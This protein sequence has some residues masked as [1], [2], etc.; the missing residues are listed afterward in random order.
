MNTNIQ[1]VRIIGDDNYIDSLIKKNLNKIPT[2]IFNYMKILAGLDTT[3]QDIQVPEHEDGLEIN[4]IKILKMNVN[5][6]I[7]QSDNV[8]IY[9]QT[10][11]LLT[12]DFDKLL[13]TEQVYYTLGFMITNKEVRDIAVK[14]QDLGN[15]KNYRTIVTHIDFDNEQ[16]GFVKQGLYSYKPRVIASNDNDYINDRLKG[17]VYNIANIDERDDDMK[18]FN[19]YVRFIHTNTIDYVGYVNSIPPQLE[20]D[21]VDLANINILQNNILTNVYVKIPEMTLQNALKM[22]MLYKDM[23]KQENILKRKMIHIK[24]HNTK[25][26]N[27]KIVVF[28]QLFMEDFKQIAN[29]EIKTADNAMIILTKVFRELLRLFYNKTIDQILNIIMELGGLNDKDFTKQQ[30]QY[31]KAIQSNK[32][33]KNMV[34]SILNQIKKESKNIN[35]EKII[36]K[37]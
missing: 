11:N 19:K 20:T 2:P 33:F 18:T 28:Y 14:T 10:D 37:F 23:I 22:F 32:I 21:Q 6:P 24:L 34:I 35:E 12:S 25:Q 8:D 16:K 9:L 3:D 5:V 4:Q 15:I 1:Q 29:N 17:S 7:P 30:Q 27:M 13:R 26:C 31:I 36:G